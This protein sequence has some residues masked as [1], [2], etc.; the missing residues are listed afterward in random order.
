MQVNFLE[1]ETNISL[2][3]KLHSIFEPTFVFLP[4]YLYP[5]VALADLFFPDPESSYFGRIHSARFKVNTATGRLQLEV[6]VYLN[7][8]TLEVQSTSDIAFN[9]FD[10]DQNPNG[11][12]YKV[13][14]QCPEPFGQAGPLTSI[15]A[16]A[17]SQTSI[18]G[19]AKAVD[20]SESTFWVSSTSSATET[21]TMNLNGQYQLAS[22]SLKWYSSS[23]SGVGF[24]VEYSL[25][26][27][28][29]SSLHAG[30]APGTST[31]SLENVEG[32]HIRLKI[33]KSVASYVILKE[34]EITGRPRQ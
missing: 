11:I 26:G 31:V 34:V 22:M 3:L 30:L 2:L 27:V 1:F 20:G 29:F 15:S 17:S 23:Y 24:D 16:S 8:V 13:L 6:G 32:T 28:H 4:G 5:R 18:Y 25:D 9:I 10:Y 7:P 12:K 19:P 21:L 33:D 14:A